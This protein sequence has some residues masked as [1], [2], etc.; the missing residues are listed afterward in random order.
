MLECNV[1]ARGQRASRM[2]VRVDLHPCW[3][4]DRVRAGGC[5]QRSEIARVDR[6]GAYETE[7]AG[8]RSRSNTGGCDI[9]HAA[10]GSIKLTPLTGTI[11]L[12][13]NEHFTVE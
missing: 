11:Q 1:A 2:P 12:N 9:P 8:P 7:P 3:R 6:R 4:R 13:G 5:R 10:P